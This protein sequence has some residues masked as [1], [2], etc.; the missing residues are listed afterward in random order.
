MAPLHHSARSSSSVASSQVRG[1]RRTSAGWWRSGL[2]GILVLA[3]CKTAEPVLVQPSF[4]TA[5]ALLVRRPADI[6]VMPVEDASPGGGATRH[7][8]FLR[9]EVMRQL[10]DRRYTPLTAGVVDAAMKGNADV[11]A[12]QAT[13]ASILEPGMLKK[14]AGHSSEDALFVLRIEHWDESNLLSS[15]RIHFRCQATLVANDG[16][17]LWFGT[18]GGEI[19]AGGAGAAPRDRDSMA[20]NC[21]EMLV[22]ELMLQLP[23]RQP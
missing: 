15:K 14:L 18:L 20:R 23:M 9:Q 21:G 22:H 2:L 11:A 7:L 1:G 6:A 13:G 8:T 10:V 5:P 17:Q 16:Q 4:T 19:K 3:G 12:A